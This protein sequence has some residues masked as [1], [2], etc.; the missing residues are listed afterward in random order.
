MSAYE[1]LPREGRMG[2]L[3]NLDARHLADI[4]LDS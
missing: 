4:L 3:L 1:W 2:N